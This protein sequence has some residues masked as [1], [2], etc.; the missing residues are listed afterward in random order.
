M[1]RNRP[2]PTP[3]RDPLDELVQLA[4]DLD[5]TALAQALG[6]ILERAQMDSLAFTDL[7]LLMLRTEAHARRERW[8]DRNRRRSR[9]GAVEGLEGFDFAA[10]PQLDPR[11]VR[12]LLNCRF[13]Q[14]KRNVLCLGRPGL[15]KTRVAKAIVQAACLAGYTTLVVNTAEMLEDFHAA[16]A[17][18]TQKRV[19]RRYTK[20]QVLLCDEFAYEPFDSKATHH[21]FRLVA[22]RHG[23][24]SIVLTANSG[25]S[26]WKKLFPLESSAIATVDRLVDRATILRFTGKSFRKPE[27]VSGAALDEDDIPSN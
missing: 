4:V 23:Q 9:L 1:A 15:G 8:L 22:A 7:A 10:R 26:Q 12:E 17:D 11:V 16:Q 14:E 2:P 27:Q 13:A 24:G 18:R 5:L 21:L 20:P 6:S 25:F 3:P 19:L